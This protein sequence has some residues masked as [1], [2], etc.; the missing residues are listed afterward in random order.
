MILQGKTVIVSGV[1]PG[2]GAEIA[3]VALRDGANVMIAARTEAKL[4]ATGERLDP[5]GA[6]IAWTTTDVADQAADEALVAATVERF[7]AVDGLVHC[8]ALDSIMGGIDGGTLAE[9]RQAFEVN[10]FGMIH[11]TRAALPHLQSR[12]GSVVFI[13]SQ[14][15]LYPQVLQL[16][17]A[18]T[19]GAQL[20]AMHHLAQEFGPS[21]VRFN[22]VVPSWMWGPPVQGYVEWQAGQSGI[23]TDA[24]LA[25]MTKNFPLREMTADEDVAEAVAFFL[26]DRS[27]KITGQS[28]LVNSGEL[29]S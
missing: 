27:S 5:T 21:G 3:A 24:M 14:T 15:L 7:G 6:R 13:G 1:G 16:V 29:M 19:K 8:A 23:T 22:T 28:L 26:S 12:R 20:G 25:E 11:L 2:L 9:W 10:F 17:Y 4:R 18:A